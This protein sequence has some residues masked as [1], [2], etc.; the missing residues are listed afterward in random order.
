[1]CLTVSEEFVCSDDFVLGVIGYNAASSTC[2]K[3]KQQQQRA[4][5][6]LMAVL[7]TML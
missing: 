3:G 5:D 2:E 6:L 7:A 4:L 1:M